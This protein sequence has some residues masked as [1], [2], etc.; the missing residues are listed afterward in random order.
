MKLWFLLFGIVFLVSCTAET[1]AMK[2]PGKIVDYPAVPQEPL[3]DNFLDFGYFARFPVCAITP[4]EQLTDYSTRKTENYYWWAY[5]GINYQ[6]YIERPYGATNHNK[7]LKTHRL[8]ITPPSRE[9]L[10][11]DEYD[12]LSCTEFAGTNL[13][14][15]KWHISIFERTDALEI[16][17][18]ADVRTAKEPISKDLDAFAK[19]VVKCQIPLPEFVS[20]EQEVIKDDEDYCLN[21]ICLA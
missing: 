11:S 14:D 2:C 15:D 4:N 19:E 16:V 13:G 17:L 10:Q 6:Y 5:N 9:A 3:L 12:F 8:I 21:H 1:P 20:P 18:S 7:L